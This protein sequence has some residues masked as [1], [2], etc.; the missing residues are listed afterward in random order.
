MK[1]QRIRVL[2]LCVF[3]HQGSILVFEGHDSQKNGSFYRPLGGGVE[4]GEPVEDALRREIREEMGEEIIHLRRLGVMENLF[5]YEGEQGHEIVFIY[6]AKFKDNSVY[7][8][9]DLKACEDDGKLFKLCWLKISKLKQLD[10]P[11]YPEG[12][13]RLL[14]DQ[15]F[16]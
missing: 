2:A 11:L 1:K 7:A 14:L 13:T 8:Q 16:S 10:Y 15:K 6:D 5:I 9:D 12:V 3:H 4:F